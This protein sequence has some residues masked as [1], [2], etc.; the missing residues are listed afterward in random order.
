MALLRFFLPPYVLAGIR[1]HVRR[2]APRPGTY[3]RTL[4]QLSYRA[5][6]AILAQLRDIANYGCVVVDVRGQGRVERSSDVELFS[7]GK[8]KSRVE[9]FKW[10]FLCFCFPN[11]RGSATCG[12]SYSRPT[13]AATSEPGSRRRRCRR[14]RSCWT[15]P[16]TGRR[17][18][19][20][21][22]RSRTAG[23]AGVWNWYKM[24]CESVAI[25]DYQ[26]V[27]DIKCRLV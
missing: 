25:Y 27:L 14:C 5:T 9:K 4:Y 18:S 17:D 24:S 2:V 23:T 8:S 12:L 15:S 1:T 22:S 11:S 7:E 21:R 3:W 16:R 6:A 13:S 20:A 10:I 26:L 19:S